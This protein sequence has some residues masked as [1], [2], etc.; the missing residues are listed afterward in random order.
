MNNKKKSKTY[1]IRWVV[2]LSLTLIVGITTPSFAQEGVAEFVEGEIIVKFK[3]EAKVKVKI[4]EEGI[5]TTGCESIDLLNR[6]FDVSKMEKVFKTAKDAEELSR[7]YKLTFPKEISLLE[8]LREY[9]QNT[10]IEY[11]EPNY[12]YKT[13]NSSAPTHQSP[14]HQ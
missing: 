6:K 4:S 7:I 14:E 1:I 2:L 3:P 13:Q 10:N 11:A 9:R 5:I 12:I 8:I